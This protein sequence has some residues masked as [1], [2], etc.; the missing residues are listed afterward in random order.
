M[1]CALFDTPQGII[2]GYCDQ[3]YE[4]YYCYGGNENRCDDFEVVVGFGDENLAMNA[5]KKFFKSDVERRI[6]EKEQEVYELEC[7]L[8]K[9]KGD[10]SFQDQMY[11]M[12]N[13]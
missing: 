2:P 3:D 4:G 5:L 10:Q 7:K 13:D 1:W 8:E 12:Y 9:L 11:H 6:A